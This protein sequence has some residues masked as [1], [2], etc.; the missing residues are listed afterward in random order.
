[1]EVFNKSNSRNTG[2]LPVL[3]SWMLISPQNSSA[4]NLSI[5]ISEVPVGSEQPIHNHEPEQCYYIIKGKGLM[6][7]EEGSKEVNAGD[8]VYI[9]SDSKHG[10]KNIGDELLEYL[11]A[12][13]PVFSEQYENTLWPSIPIKT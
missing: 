12:N 5:Q 1:M 3:T 8:A 13:S 2:E 9:P 11:T 4:Q 7:I 10:I 6:T